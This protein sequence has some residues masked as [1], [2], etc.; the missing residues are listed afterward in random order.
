MDYKLCSDNLGQLIQLGFKIN[1]LLLQIGYC[2]DDFIAQQFSKKDIVAYALEQLEEIDDD[3]IIML[4]CEENDSYE[5]TN[6]LHKLAKRERSSKE[7]QMR[8]LRALILSR[9]FAALP[10]DYM[11]G[12]I[13]LT[14]I[15]ISLGLP[16][17]CPHVIQGRYNSLSPND[18]YTK[19]M[20]ETLKMKNFNWLDREISYI[21]SHDD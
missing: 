1:W 18:Y 8:K 13:E 16:E 19:E 2:G 15:W 7:I 9:S 10:D 6:I 14:D 20:Y 21:I 5:F 12:L 4:V 17:D 3:L 11:E